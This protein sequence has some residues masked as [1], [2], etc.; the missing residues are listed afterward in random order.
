[1]A[2]IV[3]QEWSNGQV[4]QLGAS[5]DGI[6]TLLDVKQQQ[7]ALSGQYLMITTAT[8]YGT[9]FQN[10]QALR[11]G[12]SRDWLDVMQL[13]R[14]KIPR[15]TYL[16][17]AEHNEGYSSH[18]VPPT[19]FACGNVSSFSWPRITLT[20]SDW[21]TNFDFD[22]LWYAGWYDIFL[23]PQLDAFRNADT[24]SGHRQVC[25]LLLCLCT[26]CFVC[27]FFPPLL[28]S[29]VLFPPQPPLPSKSSL[30]PL[31]T[32]DCIK[33]TRFLKTERPL[34]GPLSDQLTF[35]RRQYI[36]K[37]GPRCPLLQEKLDF[38]VPQQRSGL[39]M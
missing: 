1:M 30:I 34:D 35:S 39:F 23:G 6:L 3:K 25:L 36:Q 22:A 28:L 8:P 33:S 19:G 12:L 2:W 5:A 13:Y 20:P 11:Y 21:A 38:Q 27:F 4:F 31:G 15:G 24:L 16:N 26:F 7:P 9:L 10:N 29:F 32:V 17:I 14:P 37:R 18:Y